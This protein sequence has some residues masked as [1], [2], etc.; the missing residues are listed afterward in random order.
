MNSF[1]WRRDYECIRSFR[2]WM[3]IFALGKWRPFVKIFKIES[4]VMRN[5]G[6]SGNMVMTDQDICQRHFNQSR[7]NIH[8]IMMRYNKRHS[9][10][11]NK[12]TWKC[13]FSIRE[14]KLFI[15]N[16]TSF[17]SCVV[18]YLST[19][20]EELLN[21]TSNES[22]KKIMTFILIGIFSWSDNA[23]SWICVNFQKTNN[24]ESFYIFRIWMNQINPMNQYIGYDVLNQKRRSAH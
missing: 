13:H 17:L 22:E 9:S 7:L 23:N 20:S 3:F 2:S 24:E 10:H 8:K 14:H 6:T 15:I 16:I 5:D 11:K 1:T 4:Y 21:W 18:W 19:V 12:I